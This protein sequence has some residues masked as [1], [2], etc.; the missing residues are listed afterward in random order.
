M[1]MFRPNIENDKESVTPFYI[2]LTVHD[3]LLHKSR[4]FSHEMRA[5]I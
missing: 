1:I 2:T 5:E 4:L 3:H